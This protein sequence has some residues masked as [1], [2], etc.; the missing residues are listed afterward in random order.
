MLSDSAPLRKLLAEFLPGLCISTVA[1]P[2]GQRVVY[3]ATFTA[4]ADAKSRHRAA[5]GQIVL[6]VS[7]GV[8]PSSTAYLEKEIEILNSLKSHHY[9]KLYFNETFTTNPSTGDPLPHRLFITIEER[10]DARPLRQI[11]SEYKTEK[12]LARLVSCLIDALEPL[13][14]HPQRLVHRD[15]KPEN[16]LVRPDH[17]VAIIDLGIVREE[18]SAGITAT[19]SPFGPCTALYASPEQARNDKPNISFK[20]DFF[21]I[22]VVAYELASGGNPFGTPGEPFMA[23]LDRVQNHNPPPLHEV[24]AVSKEFSAIVAKLM[25]KQPYRR[26][27]TVDQLKGV[28]TPN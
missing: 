4:G 10:I 8:D 25:E 20:S 1:S 26:F 9:P 19:G 16:I 7:A 3:F 5:W 15:I 2:S 11:V 27:R 22:G 13:W 23:I 14:N 28:L 24:S 12:K 21:S 18:G 6:K 17:T